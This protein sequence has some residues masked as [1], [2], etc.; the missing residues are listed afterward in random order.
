MKRELLTFGAGLL[1]AW[2][3]RTDDVEVGW[4]FDE[5][6]RKRVRV[7]LVRGAD[8]SWVREGEFASWHANGH[9]MSVGPMRADREEGLW[10]RY[11]ENGR[12]K[13]RLTFA[14]GQIH[15]RYES[16]Y[17][18]GQ[19]SSEGEFERGEPV[20]TWTVWHEDGSLD[21]ERSGRYVDGELVR[22]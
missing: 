7:E 12:L 11:H 6:G 3:A 2:T 17:A 10:H 19:K 9:P 22:D 15:G 18:N 1:V 16:W 4:D 21:V 5:K 14:A 20:G 8:G 13:K